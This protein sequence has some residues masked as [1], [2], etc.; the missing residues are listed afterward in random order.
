MITERIANL[1]SEQAEQALLIFYDLLPPEIWENGK[2]PSQAR[3]EFLANQL[4]EEGPPEAKVLITA[5][6]KEQSP[7]GEIAKV[8]LNQFAQYEQLQPYLEKAIAS[9]TSSDKA[10]IEVAVLIALLAFMA[11]SKY[12]DGQFSFDGDRV[13]KLVEKLPSSVWSALTGGNS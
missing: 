11:G 12:E 6:A 3:I 2:K 10:I 8:L 7:K 13:V 1:T 9:A 4:Q 5:L